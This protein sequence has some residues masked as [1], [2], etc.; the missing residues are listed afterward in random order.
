MTAAAVADRPTDRLP[1]HCGCGVYLTDFNARLAI[2]D[3]D[4][5]CCVSC[6]RKL[7]PRSEPDRARRWAKMQRE[8]RL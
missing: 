3:L 6:E 1:A 8:D 2:P 7:Q 4:V 5:W